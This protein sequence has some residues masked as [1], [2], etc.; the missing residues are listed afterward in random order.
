M[1]HFYFYSIFLFLLARFVH[2]RKKRFI[3][4]VEKKWLYELCQNLFNLF[5]RV[6]QKRIACVSVEICK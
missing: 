5:L 3:D 1:C 2:E 4:D 6:K